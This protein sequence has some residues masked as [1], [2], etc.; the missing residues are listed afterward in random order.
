MVISSF[1]GL[2]DLFDP[3]VIDKDLPDL[4]ITDKT[5]EDTV[6]FAQRFGSYC[7][8]WRIATGRFYT[9][10]ELKEKRRK[11]LYTP[12]SGAGLLEQISSKIRYWYAVLTN[13]YP[14]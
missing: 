14:E 3:S 11:I 13:K 5:R 10:K 7:S 1:G 8:D 6:R 2:D 9:D 12:L 4:K